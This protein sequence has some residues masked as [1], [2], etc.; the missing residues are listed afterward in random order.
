MQREC[1]T[2]VLDQEARVSIGEPD[3]SVPKTAGNA[4]VVALAQHATV[5]AAPF[6]T[7][8]TRRRQP[9]R[10]QISVQ[11]R[12]GTPADYGQ[13]AAQRF[14]QIPQRSMQ[15]RVYADTVRGRGDLGQRTVE[16]EEQRPCFAAL[17]VG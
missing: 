13:C 1:G 8:K 6:Q 7:V 4:A 10:G 12:D 14:E 11:V 9:E 5:C 3:E 2:L 16:I 17:G 15:R